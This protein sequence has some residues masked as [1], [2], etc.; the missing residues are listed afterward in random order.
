RFLLFG[1][2]ADLIAARRTVDIEIVAGLGAPACGFAIE[3]DGGLDRRAHDAAL[4]IEIDAALS[5]GDGGF[6]GM[7]GGV[8][9]VLRSLD[10]N[11]CRSQSRGAK[12]GASEG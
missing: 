11:G 7:Q 5:F 2:G 1:G 8:G 12:H 9:A 3:I 4:A 6:V 10:L